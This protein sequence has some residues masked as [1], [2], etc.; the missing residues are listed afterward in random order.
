MDH[1]VSGDGTRLVYERSGVGPA[2]VVV[3]GTGGSA[4]RWRPVLPA[5]AARFSVH[6]LNRRGRGGSGDTE[7][8]AL[9]REAEDVAALVEAIGEPVNVLGHSYGALCA[10]EAALLRPPRRLI[11]YEPPISVGD[12]APYSDRDGFIGRLEALLEAGEREAVVLTFMREAVQMPPD[13]L[14]QV[15]AAPSFPGRVAAAHTIP[16]E[17]RA[18]ASY[19]LRP[20]RFAGLQVPTRLLLG[21]ASPA[22]FRD[23]TALVRSALP[24]A[25]VMVLPGQQHVAIDTAPDLFVQAVVEFLS[26]DPSI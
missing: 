20:E 16:R 17:L 18:Q 12:H 13:E 26:G 1:F 24:L 5:L 14:D 23:A 25:E 22:F 6:A 21:G 15:R 4:A 3:H 10:L 19:R 9:E 2:L 11:L 7:D 8:Y